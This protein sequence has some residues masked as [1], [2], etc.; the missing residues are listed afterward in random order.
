MLP[1]RRRIVAHLKELARGDG[2]QGQAYLRSRIHNVKARIL[3]H[4]GRG[5]ETVDA[6][7]NA[8]TTLNQRLR[9][10]TLELWRARD[11]YRPGRCEPSSL[12]LLKTEIPTRWPAHDMSDPHHGWRAFVRGRIDV[13][14]IPGE[15]LKMFEGDNCERI[16]AAIAPYIARLGDKP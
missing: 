14:P 1:L 7:P 11:S 2:S 3:R 12:L 8:D 5:E 9:R 6:V 10:S 16:A 13:E 4:L 15:H